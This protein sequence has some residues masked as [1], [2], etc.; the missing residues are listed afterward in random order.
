[1]TSREPLT[2]DDLL[3]LLDIDFEDYLQGAH[4][5][6]E[7]GVFRRE[8]FPRGACI[9]CHEMHTPYPL[10]LFLPY[11]TDEEKR[12]F[13]FFCH[14]GTAAPQPSAPPQEHAEAAT[15]PCTDCHDAHIPED[16]GGGTGTGCEACHGHDAGYE[17]APGQFCEGYGTAASHSTHTEMDA[18]D[19]RGPLLD[20]D[21][22]HDTENYP[23]FK[24]GT[25]EPPYDLSETDVC[26]A[27]HSPGGAY[28]GVND[29]DV[30]A[31][32]GNGGELGFNWRNGPYDE[33]QELR[34]ETARWCIG[35]HDDAPAS[36]DPDP[37]VGIEAPDVA[38]DDATYGYYVTGHG[39]PAAAGPYPSL[40]WQA[41]DAQGNAAADVAACTRCHDGQPA[42]PHIDHVP[43]TTDRLGPGFENDQDNTNCN[44]CHPPG[45]EA[46]SDPPFY[47]T[48]A[49]FEASAHGD[50]LCTQC[51][52]VHGASGPYPGMTRAPRETL[53]FDCHT[54]GGVRNDAISG[55]ELADD[56]EQA[57]A[58][59][60]T[61]DLGANFTWGG[62]DYTLECVSCHNVHLVNGKFW[63][64]DAGD[65]T[66]VTRFP[67][68]A[69]EHLEPWGDEPGE[70]M[71]DFAALGEGTGG[72]YY[73][74][75]RGGV[76]VWDQHGVYQPPKKG[77][78][79][80]FEFDGD[81][82]PDY[83]TFCLDCH[84]YRM[85]PA[86]PP[87]NWGQG[88][89]C[90][91]NS[92]D[93]PDQRIECGAQHGL[94]PA[95][96]P[97]AWDP[98]SE[99]Y[100]S[101]G[102]PDPI[103]HE[104]YVQRGRG[105]GHFLRW[106]YEPA[107]RH[108]GI[109]FV[110]SC[111]DCHEAHGSNLPSMLRTNPNNGV[112]SGTWNV[113][114]NN[115]HYYYGYQHAGMSCGNASCHEANSIHRI[116][117]VTHSPDTDLWQEPSR[118][119]TTP[120]IVLVTGLVGSDE[121]TVVFKQGVYTNR[122][123]TGALQPS[124]FL[125]TDVGGDNPRTIEQVVHTPGD[126]V[127]TLIMSQPLSA[128]DIGV[129]LL[130]TRGLSI[131]DAESEPAGPWPVTV[132]T[133]PTEA[134]F[135]LEEPPGSP[136]VSDSSGL[137]VGTVSDPAESFPGDGF[138]HGDGIDNYVEFA[139]DPTCLMATR[140]LTL[141]AV[142]FP[143]TVDDGTGNFKQRIFAKGGPNYQVSVWKNN[144]WPNYQAPDSAASIAFWVRVADPHGG[145]N[146]KPV[147]TDY[148][149]YP[150]VAGHWYRI[151]VVWDSDTPGGIPGRIY[152]DDLGTDGAGSGE[153]WAGFVDATDADQS[154]LTE[155][156][157]LFE[158]DEILSGEG[159]FLIG[160]SPNHTLLF[161]GLIDEIRVAPSVPGGQGLSGPAALGADMPLAAWPLPY[162]GGSLRVGFVA[163]GEDAV[164]A[165][166]EIFDLR[167]RL[168]RRLARGTYPPGEYALSW[169]G[170]DGSGR[171]VPA[172]VYF[173]RAVCGRRISA[174][175]VVVAR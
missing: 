95:N 32:Y 49:A 12:A 10:G 134:L 24:S 109:N 56:I 118:P 114:C 20:C 39:R 146:W 4:G 112:G 165:S 122:D 151:R 57:F 115:C 86:N 14:D 159:P 92:V 149:A 116:I 105:A 103:F 127:A 133:C 15:T 27:C 121:L 161:H 35:C 41:R 11:G 28:D 145:T 81:V 26:D 40:S 129:D 138:F 132:P 18:D 47:T 156:R 152:V 30:G 111:T 144:D 72:W 59:A 58:F 21:A 25:G 97:Y 45:G 46:T 123:Q 51:H 8:G 139:D 2:L 7:T 157:K 42:E 117:H 22:C 23:A 68:D 1:M 36:S 84:T 90:T 74:K 113:M 62:K 130:A 9:H 96:K 70:K 76:I 82:L 91:D 107:E 78:G 63:D 17:Y 136:T 131:W 120:E 102:T 128:A 61:H 153:N 80:D 33:N 75:A 135:A 38:G 88:I 16:H 163:E 124:D 3:R 172:G 155:E 125:L 64:A 164:E 31:K 52:E 13:C 171:P 140:K 168:V 108:A 174:L 83:A 110:L 98:D 99:F 43:G 60:E 66:P 126:S 37:G 119:S 55:P 29:P 100:G 73:S 71:D 148:A 87:V 93:P 150:I 34:P 89:E 162:R 169:D 173:L 158:G 143:T 5:D 166:V 54:E 147:L 77:S 170:R 53:C 160:A 19:L 94:R 6:P 141:E 50:Q 167:G 137:L 48:S 65:K 104:P 79:Y 106:P 101:G 85:S 154:Y 175:K 67:P 44:R 69:P 142:V